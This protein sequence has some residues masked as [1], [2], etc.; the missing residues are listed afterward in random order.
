MKVPFNDLYKHHSSIRQEIDRAISNV[1]DESSFVRGQ[2]VTEFEERFS[3][4]I[5]TQHCIS[6]ANGTD[7][8]YIAVKALGLKNNQEV[9]VPAHSWISTSEIVTQA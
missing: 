2:Y 1:I 7:A 8:L 3:S 4:L 9:I 6:C 5:G